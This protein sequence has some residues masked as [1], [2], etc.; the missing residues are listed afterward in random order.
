MKAA[1]E[2]V[3]I[4][5]GLAGLCAAIHL[6]KLKH[7]VVLIEKNSYPHHKVC[8]EYISNEVLPYL[9]WL[10][11]N[12]F[13]FGA[14]TITR[15]I[16]SKNNGRSIET[17]L[18]LGG[19]GISRYTLD[20]Q[21]KAL[22]VQQGVEI[23]KDTVTII[24]GDGD[25]RVVQTKGK[26]LVTARVVLVASGK[27][28]N[29]D[30]SLNREFIQENAP[31]LAVKWHAQGDFPEDLVAL[32]NFNGGYCGVSKV[33][34][35]RINLCFIS[36]YKSFKK[37][38]DIPAFI[39]NELCKNPELNTIITNTKPLI[40]PPLSISQISFNS[41]PTIEQHNLMCGD[42][43]GLIHPL[44]GNGM[45]MAIHGA[46]IASQAIHDFLIGA[47]SQ[48]QMEQQY[49]KAWKREFSSR[50]QTG[51]AAATIF[52]NQTTMHAAYSLM[53]LVPKVLPWLI[54]RTHGNPINVD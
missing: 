10:G 41:K 6:R 34:D 30:K 43:A 4:G 28:S 40:N 48:A 53:H 12:P 22:A 46:K 20:N 24:N 42:A 15:L 52:K 1:C 45:G 13:D 3:I 11:L 21:L 14:T 25:K 18:P 36:T 32:H 35:Q 51:R 38:K 5:G 54:K 2:V 33:E 9:K 23:I 47:C 16:V 31:F 49:T 8:G 26:A 29:L 39:K 27:R 50:L 17:N 37:H 19:F 44:C 7:E